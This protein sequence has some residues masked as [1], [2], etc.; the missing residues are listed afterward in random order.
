MGAN[1][2][3]TNVNGGL[4]VAVGASGWRDADGSVTQFGG[5][6]LRI[7][8]G[9]TVNPVRG[10]KGASS[11][12]NLRGD[13]QVRAGGI[14]Q[15]WQTWIL[16]KVCREYCVWRQTAERKAVLGYF[17]MVLKPTKGRL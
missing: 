7:D 9:G 3:Q 10:T 11:V 15:T 4:N 2:D 5:G 13:I 8:A 14:G 17:A 6:D 16:V 12:N 1:R